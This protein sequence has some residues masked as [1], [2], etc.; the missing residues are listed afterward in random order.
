MKKIII[1]MGL[2]RTAS[3]ML[4]TQL[5]AVKKPLKV[6][7]T[8]LL[9]REDMEANPAFDMRRWH[10][11]GFLGSRLMSGLV[12]RESSFAHSVNSLPGWRIII[13]DENLVGTMPGI[14]AGLG[15]GSKFYPQYAKFVA[16]LKRLDK[17]AKVYPRLVVRRQDG[18]LESIYAFRVARGL[19]L[20]FP[21]F[22]KSFGACTFDFNPFAEA[23]LPFGIRAE[24]AVIE[25]W[26]KA[27]NFAAA[28]LAF[29]GAETPVKPLAGR[30]NRRLGVKSLQL[31]LALN[32]LKLLP[33]QVERKEKLFPALDEAEKAGADVMNTLTAMPLTK[34]QLAS[35]KAHIG[36][37]HAVTFTD[38]D[39][40]A[41]LAD[42]KQANHRFLVRPEVKA[43]A[44][45]WL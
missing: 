18:L 36:E 8:E 43:K 35:I 25:N 17:Y 26:Q 32:R 42:L 41:F 33:D 38:S 20:D 39:R 12:S 5:K 13:S 16:G 2:H 40:E 10:R 4:Q 28:A 37:N 44:N 3:T 11:G 30:G 15:G 29:M 9:L 6:L 31:V 14:K 21:D 19:T 1:H 23:L 7:A 45:I 34:E 27:D 22:V 24:I